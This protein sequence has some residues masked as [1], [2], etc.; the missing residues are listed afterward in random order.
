[1]SI[2]S[3]PTGTRGSRDEHDVRYARCVRRRL[4]RV[5]AVALFGHL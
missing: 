1:M 5:P 3:S 2:W 4:L